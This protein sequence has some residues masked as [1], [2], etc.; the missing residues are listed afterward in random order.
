MRG[1][2]SSKF[3]EIYSIV[4]VVCNRETIIWQLKF[5]KIFSLIFR[6]EIVFQKIA[7]YVRELAIWNYLKCHFK[8]LSYSQII[9]LLTWNHIFEILE[10]RKCKF[11]PKILFLT[12]RSVHPFSTSSVTRCDDF[13]GLYFLY[14]SVGNL[15]KWI[16]LN[17][18]KIY[19][20]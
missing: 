20:V 11:L 16:I 2:G 18:E 5:F 9:F 10:K 1:V 4:I 7:V 12:L 14:K 15:I 3:L 17:T 8:N 19:P 6:L 13:F